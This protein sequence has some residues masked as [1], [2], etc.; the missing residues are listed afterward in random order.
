MSR[1][2]RTGYAVMVSLAAVAIAIVA[3]AILFDMAVWQALVL[4]AVVDAAIIL[5]G[6]RLAKGAARADKADSA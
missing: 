6:Y 1:T 2:V 5:G 4:L 3:A